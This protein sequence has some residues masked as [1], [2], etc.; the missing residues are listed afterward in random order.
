MAS[1]VMSGQVFRAST[2]EWELMPGETT[3]VQ[4][5][6]DM[7]REPQF[8]GRLGIELRGVSAGSQ[9]EAFRVVV[10]ARVE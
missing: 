1:P 2:A 3:V 4:L 8:T 7:S 10:K 6:L 9:S 5:L